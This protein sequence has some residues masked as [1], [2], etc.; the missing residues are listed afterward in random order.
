MSPATRGLFQL[1][2]PCDLFHHPCLCC[3]AAHLL[4]HDCG[5]CDQRPGL[6]S[7]HWKVQFVSAPLIPSSDQT[8]SPSPTL[9][10][11]LISG[12]KA[13]MQTFRRVVTQPDIV[14]R[15]RM[16]LLVPAM[17]LMDL[18]LDRNHQFQCE[19]YFAGL[20]G[21]NDQPPTAIIFDK[22]GHLFERQSG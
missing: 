8:S 13:Q 16:R 9:H 11:D 19:Q 15:R 21:R 2:K 20:A 18:Y 7:G 1:P 14:F 12:S 3:A 6:V 17:A 10:D 4:N 5:Q 22:V